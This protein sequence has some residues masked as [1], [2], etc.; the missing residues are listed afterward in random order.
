VSLFDYGDPITPE[1]IEDFWS[2]DKDLNKAIDQLRGE[3][4]EIL[5]EPRDGEATLSVRAS[6]E[7]YEAACKGKLELVEVRYPVGRRSYQDITHIH[8]IGESKKYAQFLGLIDGQDTKKMGKVIEGIDIV[9][10][11]QIFQTPPHTPDE[12]P[13]PNYRHL[14]VRSAP[15]SQV[16]VLSV[17]RSVED[18]LRTGKAR[19]LGVT[20]KGV[21]VV[22]IDTGHDKSH[23][24][25]KDLKENIKVDQKNAMC[26]AGNIEEDESGHGTGISA[27]LFAVAPDVTLTPIKL[28]RVGKQK[29]S[30]KRLQFAIGLEWGLKRALSLANVPD[31]ITC[32]L[33]VHLCKQKQ[34]TA[35]I[36]DDSPAGP[37][38]QAFVKRF[39]GLELEIARA[40][41]E[42]GI[43]II[44][45]AGNNGTYGFPAQ[46]N[47]VIAAGGV[48]I[49]NRGTLWASSYA[50]GYESE[51]YENR[52]VPDVC[53]LCGTR[54][55][56]G[57]YIMMPVP[58]GSQIDVRCSSRDE[59]GPGD[60]WACFSGTSAAAP[61]LAGV[62]ALM[63]EAF[64]ELHPN[65][66]R[67][68]MRATARDV[69]TGNSANGNKAAE[70]ND[71]AT[72]SGLVDAH[73]SVQMT[74]LYRQLHAVNFSH[75]GPPSLPAP[76]N[77]PNLRR[78]VDLFRDLGQ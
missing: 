29:V 19:E 13:E 4:F 27:N 17:P 44:F 77:D 71:L 38:V 3:G 25:F 75:A 22:L 72:G 23:K 36:S 10:P 61:Q 54:A 67:Y 43:V 37:N 30:K 21:H 6:P 69:K 57:R 40:W 48:Y 31:I 49:D 12:P 78:L 52:I 16:G 1:N 15:G 33:G 18:A 8:F 76:E 34:L 64:P 28:K 74:Q 70:G 26:G 7:C 62:A 2:N 58:H 65:H 41:Q 68:I 20:G 39:V 53:G 51:I 56:Y 11:F 50:S 9:T 32:S 60:G 63:L 5:R 35:I 42:K 55:T 24:F 14:S 45:S 73:R 66:T 59:T 46:S 47:F